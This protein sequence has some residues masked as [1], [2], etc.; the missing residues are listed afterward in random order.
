MKATQGST[1]HRKIEDSL[2]SELTA[3]Q[4]VLALQQQDNYQFQDHIKILN[5]EIDALRLMLEDKQ[6]TINS[7]QNT[8][9]KKD[10]RIA[11]LEAL[12]YENRIERH[13]FKT[14]EHQNVLLLGE[15]KDTKAKME[16]LEVEVRYLRELKD[17]R[18]AYDEE[19]IKMI[20][21]MEIKLNGQHYKYNYH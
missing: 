1:N 4:S 8:V 17:D 18:L 5:G 20:A 13:A 9:I 12:L 2:R 21:E 6:V 16:E 15:L 7:L 19:K 3:A 14:F 11:E 10:D